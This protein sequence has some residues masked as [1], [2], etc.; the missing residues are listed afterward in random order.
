[1]V[2]IL[3]HYDWRYIFTVN[4]YGN[5]GQKG[6]AELQK[7]ASASDICI[8]SSAQLPSLPNEKDFDDVIKTF[9]ETS[10]QHSDHVNVIVVFTTQADS[11]DI[12]RAATKKNATQFTWVGSN[13]WSNR[14]DVTDGNEDVAEGSL[15][16]NHLEG[17][18]ARFDVHF[19]NMKPKGN[20][21]NPW[22]EEFWEAIFKCSIPAGN[23]DKENELPLCQNDQTLPPAI[24]LAPVRVVINAVYAMAHAL[25]NL[26]QVYCPG[27]LGMCDR[28]RSE[29]QRNDL[30]SFLRNVTFPDASLNFSIRFNQK[31][32]NGRCLR[33]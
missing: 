21:F 18:V 19:K 26:Q 5:Y 11:E 2:D 33:H 4:S 14:V 22:F 20:E 23:T 1:M 15:T 24:E 13:G 16:V 25:H 9:L 12:L 32:G 8:A 27:V 29:F 10:T 31:P 28:M 6:M 30:L 17:D 7:A 3:K